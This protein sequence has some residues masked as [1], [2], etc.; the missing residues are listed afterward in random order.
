MHHDASMEASDK[1]KGRTVIRKAVVI[2]DP[3]VQKVTPKLG[4]EADRS[5]GYGPNP[6]SR[7]RFQTRPKGISKYFSVCDGESPSLGDLQCRIHALLLQLRASNQ[8]GAFNSP[9]IRVRRPDVFPESLG[10]NL[11]ISQAFLEL[12]ILMAPPRSLLL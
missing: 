9:A 6:R 10:S 7:S 11:L 3:F 1:V 12:G 4:R 8:C 5:P 2:F